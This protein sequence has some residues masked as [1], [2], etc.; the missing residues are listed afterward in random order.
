MKKELKLSFKIFWTPSAQLDLKYWQ[1]NNPRKV[2]RIKS[3]CESIS[4]NPT[5]GI[6][7]P[8][9]LKFLEGDIWS[10]RIDQEH[11]IVYELK[12]NQ[13]IFIIQARYHY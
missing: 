12:T 5:F 13:K 4:Q 1:K 2:K 7:K 6:G 3:L 11:R 10:R 9:K 8:E